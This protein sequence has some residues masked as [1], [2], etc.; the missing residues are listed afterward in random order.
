MSVFF[1]ATLNFAWSFPLIFTLGGK[2]LKTIA[3]MESSLLK[4]RYVWHRVSEDDGF[5]FYE[6]CLWTNIF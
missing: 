6:Y 4:T 1:K 5:S 2:T 3:S